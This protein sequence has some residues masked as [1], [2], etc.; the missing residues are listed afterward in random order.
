MRLS[1]TPPPGVE[2]RHGI[3]GGSAISPDGRSIVFAAIRDGK[4]QLWLRHL[5]SL[6]ARPLPG[7]E[8]GVLPFWSPDGRSIGFQAAGKLRRISLS[9]GPASDLAAATRPTRGGWTENGQIL[10]AAGAGGPI[11][12]VSASG[13]TP[14]PVTPDQRGGASW[15]VPVPG[16][17]R[18]LYFE[19]SSRK[20]QYLPVSGGTQPPHTLLT[21]ES[22][23][24]FAPPF[25]GF[26]A[27]LLWLKGTTLVAQAFDPATGKLHGE[28]VPV[29]EGVGFADK[30]RLVDLS[31]S[32]NGVLAFGPGNTVRTR[33]AWV[34]RDGTILEYVG[35]E[36]WLRAVRL[37][38]DGRQALIERGNP[39]ALWI[40]DF[41]RSVLTRATFEQ[42]LRGWPVW[43]PDG[44]RIAYS[45]EKDDRISLYGRN[46]KGGRPETLIHQSSFDDYLYDWS[47][48]G[49]Y[50]I[51]CEVNPQTRLDLW[52]LPL[53]GDRKPRP[54]LKTPFNEDWPQ[55]SPDGRWV[56]YVSDESG[57]N[58]V[59]V[60]S[61]PNAEG[62]WQISTEG[63]SMPR[64]AANGEI[65]F[66]SASARIMAARTRT[67]GNR[68]E[69]SSPRS[70]FPNPSPGRIFDA[71][72]QGNRFL[73]M[74][75]VAGAIR[76]EIT[77]VVNW[78][79]AL[80][81]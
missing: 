75:P 41:E 77:V 31:V 49:N 80:A 7:T 58:E 33:L 29:A 44:S 76:N 2:L 34:R 56:A 69:W 60:T 5:N 46:A 51:Y 63:G 20:I 48:D 57:R 26:P 23:V 67:R 9:G 27:H 53:A 62:K 47:R 21:A 73:M 38:A 16:T 17:G 66:E 42:E 24:I 18:F 28:A 13:G 35:D 3:R 40:F 19:N 25:G 8:Y 79:A 1:I 72:P 78:Q 11:L 39:R 45:G 54:F 4:P 74:T 6:D 50:L 14:S 68:I 61:F 43:S 32:S 52:L 12:R 37:S 15:P 10:F 22:S 64:W 55:F 65:F 70:L 81:K 30:W 36:D 71:A 59:Y